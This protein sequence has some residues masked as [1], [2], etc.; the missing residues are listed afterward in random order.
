MP[1][2]SKVQA[3]NAL[4]ATS[5]LVRRDSSIPGL[6]LMLD[7]ARLL[8]GM[9]GQLDSSRVDDIKLNY[10][11]YKPGMNCLARYELRV[12]GQTIH[13]YA[14]SHGQDATSKL[15]KAAE[16]PVIESILGPGR[17]ILET[18]RIVFS[19]FPND[20]KLASLQRLGEIGYRQLLFRRVFGENS[21]WQTSEFIKVL[22]YKPERRCVVRLGRADGESALAKFYTHSGFVNART[23]S[24]RMSS[25]SNRNSQYPEIIGRS[26]KHAVIAYRWWP[27]DSLR[28]LGIVGKLS[29]S[30]VAETAR[31][32]SKF[33]SSEAT[34]LLALEPAGRAERLSALAEHIG[35]VL[36]HLQ[37]RAKGVAQGLIGWLGDQP[38]VHRPVHGDFYDKQVI[39]ESGNVRL[40]DLDGACLDNPLIDLGSYVAHLEMH[41]INDG[42]G[43]SEIEVHQQTLVTAYEHSAGL[44]SAAA[45]NKYIAL[46]L[47]GLIHHPF[48]DWTD[49]WPVKTESLLQRVETLV[50]A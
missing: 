14:K 20:A 22:N 47:F 9:R 25:E 28:E 27:G 50:A 1:C 26:K 35:F 49:N 44:V 2:E 7:P 13:A 45:L 30:D 38:L 41:A 18:E 19:T 32:L 12:E 3:D 39:V 16:R 23:I 21:D 8:A 37:Q 42:K 11:R 43:C 4:T 46:G 33:H 5:D 29:L 15:N 34:G 40:I 24:R 6:G 17:V 31:V 48:R 36:P 10:L